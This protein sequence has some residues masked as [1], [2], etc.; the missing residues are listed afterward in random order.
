MCCGYEDRCTGYFRSWS[1]KPDRTKK[2]ERKYG[3][4]MKK[5]A[6]LQS[7]YMAL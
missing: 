4:E 1:T 2:V 7:P 3:V 6:M 5:I